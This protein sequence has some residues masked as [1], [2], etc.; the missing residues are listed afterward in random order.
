MLFSTYIGPL[1]RLVQL[2]PLVERNISWGELILL[3]PTSITGSTTAIYGQND[4]IGNHSQLA[5]N[6]SCTPPTLLHFV[7]FLPL[8]WMLF[9]KYTPY[10]LLASSTSKFRQKKAEM[11]KKVCEKRYGVYY[12]RPFF[13]IS[14]FFCLFQFLHFAHEFWNRTC[15]K[16]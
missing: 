14:A 7:A 11:Q 10:L 12:F 9:L 2:P 16:Q 4:Q 6:S 15:K 5:R 13:C 1:K 3:V 8:F